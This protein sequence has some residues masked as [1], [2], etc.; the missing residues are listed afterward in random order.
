MR[1]IGFKLTLIMVCIVV[2]GIL[3]TTGVA[4]GISGNVISRESLAKAE[5]NNDGE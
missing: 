2:I 3:A 1:G 4:V 5:R